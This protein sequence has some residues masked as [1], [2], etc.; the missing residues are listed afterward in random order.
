MK[1][2]SEIRH[3]RVRYDFQVIHYRGLNAVEEIE[4]LI[5][6]CA[7]R[8]KLAAEQKLIQTSGSLALDKFRFCTSCDP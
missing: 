4:S 8:V 2:E 5:F 1:T 3:L 6:Y 7:L